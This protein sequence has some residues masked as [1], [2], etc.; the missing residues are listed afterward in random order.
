MLT[1]LYG[2]ITPT[3]DES[4]EKQQATGSSSPTTTP[5][6]YQRSASTQPKSTTRVPLGSARSSSM[7]YPSQ[8]IYSYVSG[9]LFGHHNKT[10]RS[11]AE[12]A[13][14]GDETSVCSWIKEGCDPDE[15][16]AYG[17]TPLLNAATIGRVNAVAEL[18]RNGADV[19][20]K[21]PFGFSPLHA[22]A[23]VISQ[24]FEIF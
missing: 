11:L 19:N 14:C 17:Y 18:I 13:E 24:H 23:Q 1:V 9:L 8:G 10:K 2:V 16:D 6:H 5:P 12:E 22:A 15:V 20:K 21:G 4:K 3:N 7:A